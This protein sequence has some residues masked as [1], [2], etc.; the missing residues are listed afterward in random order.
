MAL[1]GLPARVEQAD[2]EDLP[3]ESN[4][5]DLVWSWGVIHHSSRTAWIMRQIARVLRPEGEARIMVY[6]RD[7]IVARLT[8]A[9]HYL[10]TLQGRGRTRDEVLWANSDGAWARHY[11]A[12][13]LE[14]VLRAFFS[15]VSSQV[16]GQEA[17]V[18]PLPSR[19][20][21]HIA[22]RLRDETKRKL[23]AKQG[24]FLFATARNPIDP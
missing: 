6:N 13:G 18:V 9:R 11:T 14:D 23:A 15:D 21:K 3:F 8:L 17:D 2:A 19:F 16:L 4:S 1:A 5:F 20:R 10:S 12:D 22:P 7:S 24:S